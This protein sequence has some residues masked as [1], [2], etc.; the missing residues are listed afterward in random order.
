MAAGPGP[1]PLNLN[2]GDEALDPPPPI[3]EDPLDRI[4][5]YIPPPGDSTQAANHASTRQPTIPSRPVAARLMVSSHPSGVGISLDGEPAG[6]TPKVFSL[7][8]GSY[9][10][11]FE[12][13]GYESARQLVD[14]DGGD[15]PPLKVDLK[16]LGGSVEFLSVPSGAAVFVDG[17]LRGSTPVQVKLPGRS[18]PVYDP[19]GRV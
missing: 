12:K 14:L 11:E 1:D 7:E 3:D 5:R 19:E 17:K 2:Q 13:E 8:P 16:R 4:P 15:S 9:L 6:I 18:I 10:V